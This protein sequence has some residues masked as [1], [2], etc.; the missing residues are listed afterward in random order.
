MLAFVIAFL[1]IIAQLV[2]TGTLQIGMHGTTGSTNIFSVP[3]IPNN[4]LHALQ[5]IFSVH[6]FSPNMSYLGG[7]FHITNIIAFAAVLFVLFRKKNVFASQTTDTLFY[8]LLFSAL[9]AF[10]LSIITTPVDVY[11]MDYLAVLLLLLAT[12]VLLTSRG[13]LFTG[14]IF[15]IFQFYYFFMEAGTTYGANTKFIFLI[16]MAVIIFNLWFFFIKDRSITLNQ[17]K[18][19]PKKIIGKLAQVCRN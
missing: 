12:P 17:I 8:Q 6:D 3:S 4:I 15:S 9:L 14:L 11:Y 16:Y 10:V 5:I 19:V 2:S 1:Y 7:I 18:A 13:I